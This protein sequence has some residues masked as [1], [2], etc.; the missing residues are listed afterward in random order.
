MSWLTPLLNCPEKSNFSYLC[1]SR[2]A[3]ILWKSSSQTIFLYYLSVCKTFNFLFPGRLLHQDSV[4][5]CGSLTES[6]AGWPLS[7]G[8]SNKA[9]EWQV[10]WY[11]DIQQRQSETGNLDIH[12]KLKRN[13]NIKLDVKEILLI[14]SIKI[15][16]DR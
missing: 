2:L 13:L 12:W 3:G 11:L 6:P 4:R 14:P 15:F 7:Q 10:N 16:N 8:G 1:L 5:G 9:A